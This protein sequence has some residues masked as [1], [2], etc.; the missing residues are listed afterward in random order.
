[1]LRMGE[2]FQTMFYSLGPHGLQHARLSCPSVSS[3]VGSNSC[4]LNWWCHPTILSSIIRFS[5]CFQFFPSS[6]FFLMSK[7]FTSGGQNIGVS[8]LASV[9]AMNFQRWFP[10][11]LTDFISLQSKG[12]WRVFSNTTVQKASILW[13]S[14]FFMVQLSHPYMNVYQRNHSFH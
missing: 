14:V 9:L 12:L 4:P 3:R 6:G 8:V 11:G 1:M 5:S 13:H 10:L 2:T 7:L